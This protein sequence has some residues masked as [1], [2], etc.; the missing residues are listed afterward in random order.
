MIV[1]F[2]PQ[3]QVVAG[4]I[5]LHID[6]TFFESLQNLERT[7]FVH[8]V[9]SVTYPLSMTQ[10]DGFPN[11][12]A[13]SLRRNKAGCQFA[14]MKGDVNIRKQMLGIVNHLHVLMV[15]PHGKES[16]LWLNQIN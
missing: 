16:V 4:Q 2:D 10:F 6:S 8:D 15:V 3:D 12:E 11:V 13:K 9:Y 7:R 14:R 1:P 5:D